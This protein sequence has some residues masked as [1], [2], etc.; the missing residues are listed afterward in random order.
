MGKVREWQQGLFTR[1]SSLSSKSLQFLGNMFEFLQQETKVSRPWDYS[2]L[3]T[4]LQ[5]HGRETGVSSARNS[6]RL[7][8]LWFLV[9]RHK[10]QITAVKQSFNDCLTAVKLLATILF[11][12]YGC[13]FAQRCIL[14]KQS[15]T[16]LTDQRE[17]NRTKTRKVLQD[18]VWVFL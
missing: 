16:F 9:K 17:V 11:E 12:P 14:K 7:A 13:S 10:V 6:R 4:R 18:F 15:R 5:S 1:V 3:R 2:L 8:I